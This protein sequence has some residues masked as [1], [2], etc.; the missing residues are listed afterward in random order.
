MANKLD[1]D[2]ELT[3]KNHC[4]GILEGVTTNVYE[5]VKNQMDAFIVER[6]KIQFYERV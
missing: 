6:T 1:S 5:M 2:R 3:F 4:T